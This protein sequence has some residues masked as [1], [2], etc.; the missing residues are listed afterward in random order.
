M[1]NHKLQHQVKSL[2]LW[3]VYIYIYIKLQFTVLP[4]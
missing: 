2:T 1:E 3:T 4:F